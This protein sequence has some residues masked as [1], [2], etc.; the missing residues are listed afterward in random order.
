[1]KHWIVVSAVVLSGVG[2]AK[3]GV[4]T[5]PG[6]LNP[7][8]TLIDFE[9][10]DVGTSLPLYDGFVHITSSLNFRNQSARVI[11]SA[12]Y[13]VQIPGVVEGHLVGHLPVDYFIE[14]DQPVSQFGMGIFDPNF[15]GNV[16]RAVD[17]AGNTLEEV[18][19]GTTAF[20]VGPT[21]GSFAT[22]VG[23][24]RP[25]NDISRIELIHVYSSENSIGDFL[26]IDNVTYYTTP[27]DVP[28]PASMTLA[29][30]GSLCV[31]GCRLR[32]RFS[33]A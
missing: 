20:P 5:D 21:G 32:R 2:Q 22:Y 31:G 3:A 14:F 19:S 11:A 16:L 29:L 25:T 15:A 33:A 28:E 7:D 23:F 30:L 4:I 1:M 27:S 13:Y 8:A 17:S 12:S 26:S 9:S 10:L 18:T 24:V 6:A